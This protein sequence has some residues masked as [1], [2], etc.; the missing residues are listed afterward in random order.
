MTRAQSVSGAR[1]LSTAEKSPS[2]PTGNILALPANT[3]VRP[4]L[5]RRRLLSQAQQ[6]LDSTLRLVQFKK[7]R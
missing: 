5:L 7:A 6:A 1:T 4:D 2:E 3:Q